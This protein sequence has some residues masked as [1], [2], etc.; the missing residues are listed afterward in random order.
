MGAPTV[1][2]SGGIDAGVGRFAVTIGAAAIT[3]GYSLLCLIVYGPRA[4]SFGAVTFVAL[5]WI[6][7]GVAILVP[8]AVLGLAGRLL[9]RQWQPASSAALA[10]VGA[11]ML[12][13]VTLG[14]TGLPTAANE[15]TLP[16][17]T[18]LVAVAAAVAG[19]RAIRPLGMAAVVAVT[20]GGGLFGWGIASHLDVRVVWNPSPMRAAA[21]TADLMFEASESGDY[22]VR[23]G[24]GGCLHG[25]V[26]ATGRYGPGWEETDGLPGTARVPLGDIG[27]GEGDNDVAVCVRH[28]IATGEARAFVVAD[29]TAPPRATLDIQPTTRLAG[30]GDQ[31]TATTRTLDFSGSTSGGRTWLEING[32]PLEHLDLEDGRWSLHWTLSDVTDQATF[33]VVVEDGAGNTTRSSMIHVRFVGD[34]PPVQLE[35]RPGL[36]VECRGEPRLEAAACGAWATA[37][38]AAHP[39]F[40]PSARRFIL[41]MANEYGTCYAESRGGDGFTVL[42]LALPCP[43]DL[44]DLTPRP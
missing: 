42:G 13:T 22:E 4:D 19:G 34:P 20:V 36:S 30:D 33:A 12:G 40:L 15:W 3:L 31:R 43:D 37:V 35:G 21:A 5:Q 26:I 6:R 39:E 17:I 32:T 2:A 25:R 9:R 8:A 27:L 28:G 11:A 16:G 10:L 41:A 38:L 1:P 24:T 29:D 44:P 7:L 14:W 23:V 18:T